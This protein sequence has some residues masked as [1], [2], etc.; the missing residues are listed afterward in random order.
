MKNGNYLNNWVEV[1]LVD[2]NN[3]HL[4]TIR[5]FYNENL[6]EFHQMGPHFFIKECDNKIVISYDG[7]LVIGKTSNIKDVTINNDMDDVIIC[8]KNSVG[9]YHIK[10][11]NLITVTTGSG[12]VYQFMLV[13][14]P[15]EEHKRTIGW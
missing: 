9:Y 14:E 10:V 2:A 7:N 4:D 3:N 6:N 15:I 8:S 1:M 5:T 11:K 13:N 12:S